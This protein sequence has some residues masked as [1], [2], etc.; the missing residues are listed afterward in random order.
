MKMKEN[1]FEVATKSKFR[2]P[3]KGMATVE[4]LWDLTL[5]NLDLVFKSLNSQLKQTKEE[6]LL[7]TKSKEDKELEI[8]IDIVKHIV[9]VKLEE[10]AK[11]LKEKETKEKKQRILEILSMKQDQDLQNKSIEE[12]Q[13]MLEELNE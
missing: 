11:R 9:N 7:N 10:Q 2:F 8:K 4:D 3:Y 1:I 5:E 12:L 13:K 6:S